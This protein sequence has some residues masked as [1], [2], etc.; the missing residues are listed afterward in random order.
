LAINRIGKVGGNPVSYFDPTG[1]QVYLCQRPAQILGGVVPHYWIRTGTVEAGMGGD[2]NIAPGQQY[3]SAYVT[4][5]FIRDHS[6]DQAQ[7]C[8][9]V[10][11]VSEQC[12]NNLL[13]MDQPIGQFMPGLNDCRM[14]A[15][16]V[17]T[18]CRTRPW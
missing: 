16:T 9:K 6:K 18:S 3:E 2:P 17:L 12:V 1:L 13:R 10:E 8:E 11:N 7:S 15:T 14:F 4:R 5:V